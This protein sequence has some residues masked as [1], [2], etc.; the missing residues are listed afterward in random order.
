MIKN[1]KPY[2]EYKESGLPWLGRCP[3]HWVIKRGKSYMTTIDQRSRSGKEELLTVSS[4]RGII[5]RS[6]AKVTMFKAESYVGYKLCWPGDLVINSLWA[7]GG[8]LGVS[9]HH[10]VVS[11]AYS[12]YRPRSSAKL[13]SKFLHELVRSSAFNWEFHVRSKGIWI[14]RLQLTDTAFLNSPI[15][16]PPPEEQAAIVRFLDH[17]NGK[18]DRFIRA[19]KKL[20][21]LLNEQKQAIIH[22]AVT[23]GLNPNAPL[24]S[25]GIPWLGDIPE[26]WEVV[27]VKQATKIL[28]GKFTHRPRNDPSLYD[29][30]YPFIQTG[31]VS[32]AH[33]FITEYNQ[34][35]NEQG[36]LVSKLFPKGTLCMTIAANIGDVAILDFEACFPDSIVGFV[37]NHFV[38]RDYLFMLFKCLKAEFLC[39]APVNTQGNLNV[40]RVGV[41]PVPL[42]PLAEQHEIV[43]YIESKTMPLNAAITRTEKQIA[44]MQEYRTRLTADV[45]TGKLDVRPAVAYLPDIAID[46]TPTT[47]LEFENEVNEIESMEQ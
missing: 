22:H 27:R 38:E 35:L 18:I 28:R 32:R 6:S 24:K 43:V 20:I 9:E 19:K 45:V 23:R 37:P 40:D 3:K 11:T 1:L 12:V 14:S 8:G 26:H 15:P 10:G 29:G 25:T 30:K 47:A 17:A 7:W 31:S 42:P 21:T 2:P 4:A 36:F 33:K 13:N 41:K 44:L 5:P 46:T 39:D 16:L 34:T